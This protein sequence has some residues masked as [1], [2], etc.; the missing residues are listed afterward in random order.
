MCYS[1][2]SDH[3]LLLGVTSKAQYICFFFISSWSWQTACS[4]GR[5]SPWDHDAFPPFQISPLFSKNF[6]TLKKNFHN[7]TFSRQISWFSSAEISDD[8]FFHRPQ[9]SNFPPFSGFNTFPPVLRKLLF[10]L[11]LQISLLFS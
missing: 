7:F 11:L 6:L 2:E 9:I 3:V 8:L 5:P 10:P 1:L 4:Q